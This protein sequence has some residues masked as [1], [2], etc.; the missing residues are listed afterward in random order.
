MKLAFPRLQDQHPFLI[1]HGEPTLPEL[2][3]ESWDFQKEAGVGTYS[4]FCF[5][6]WLKLKTTCPLWELGG[7]LFLWL[8]QRQYRGKETHFEFWPPET[9]SLGIDGS[10]DKP[11]PVA[12]RRWETSTL[13]VVLPLVKPF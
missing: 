8:G 7:F 11:Q 2:E 4:S 10:D 9:S 6:I 12:H 3:V 5:S 1:G 13:E